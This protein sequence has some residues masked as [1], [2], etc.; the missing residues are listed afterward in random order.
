MGKKQILPTLADAH[1]EL[2]TLWHSTKNGALTPDMVTCGSDRRVW[3]FFPYDDPQTGKHFD[4]EWKKSVKHQI[5]R[6]ECPFVAG[7]TVYAGFNDLATKYPDLAA[8]WH[9]TKN[10][11]LKPDM[12]TCGSGQKVY[13]WLPYDDPETGKHFE[14]EW[15]E[16]ISGRVDGRGCPF[17]SGQKVWPGFNDLASKIPSIASQWHPEKNG[18]LTPKMVSCGSSK[19]VWWIAS[20]TDP[21]SGESMD[22]E[23]EETIKSRISTQSLNLSSKLMLGHIVNNLAK[24][25]PDLAAQW[26]PTKNG[27][28][29]PDK[30]AC[31]SSKEVWWYM[32]YDDP[33]TGKHFDFEWSEQIGL[34]TLY[35]NCPFLT[36]RRVWPGFNDLATKRPDLAAQWHP[37]KNGDLTPDAITYGS[38]KNIWWYMPYDDPETG[39]HFDFEWDSYLPNR[40]KDNGCPFLSGRRIWLGFND[41]ASKRP[42]LAAQWHP[43]KNGSLTPEMVTCGSNKEVWWYMPYDDPESGEHFNFEWSERVNIRNTYS[44]CP[45]LTSYR[46]WPGFNDLASKAP[47]LASQWHPTKN[48]ALSSEMV[49]LHSG[50]KVWWYMPYDDP[51]TGKHFDFE[52]ESTVCNRS[53]GL[54]CP[55][56]SGAAVWPGFNDLATKMPELAAQWHSTKNG[57]LTPEMVTCGCNTEVWWFLPYDDPETGNHFDFEWPATINSRS[58]GV[59]CPYLSGAAVWQGFNDL[60]T[61]MP[62]LAAQWH[63]TKNGDLTPEMV[64]CGSMQKI[65][66]FFPYDDPETGKHFDFEWPATIADRCTGTGCPFLSGRAVWVGYNDLA[67]KR[68]DLVKEWH[69]SKNRDLTSEMVTCGYSEKVWWFLPYDD[70]ETGEHFNFEWPATVASRVQGSGCPFLSGREIYPGFNDLATKR[71]DLA[72]QWHPTKNGSLMPEM[73]TTGSME[74][75]RWF[76][77]YDDPITGKHFDFEWN[78]TVNSRNSGSGCPYLLGRSVW[79]GFNDLESC[80]PDVAVEWHPVRNR[81]LTAVKV[82]KAASQKVWWKCG[83]CGHEWYASVKG[84]TIDG[85]GCPVCR[86]TMYYI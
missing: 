44:E 19:K 72:A 12:V 84:R 67:T 81:R 51:E 31:N 49:T 73:V 2:V 3:W 71:P 86:K 41:L 23:W 80:H 68:P 14:F 70:P 56:L 60:A 47:E 36:G 64:T 27:K 17:L 21:L 74:I 54:G 66:W 58:H 55:Y 34:R 82:F 38:N 15:K 69:P 6:P 40:L 33:D 45:F 43:T 39:K 13:W 4:F 62:E 10:G 61:K 7:R 42:D 83:R 35:S 30:V 57:D 28:L 24:M 9:P 1:P 32:P 77:P 29:T 53:K 46:V 50:E 75:V 20:Y 78:A 22:V 85:S 65:W 25:R 76:L 37:T 11:D 59:G 63:P 79:P 18:Y 52:W 48:E 16:R 26:H 5:A 8:E